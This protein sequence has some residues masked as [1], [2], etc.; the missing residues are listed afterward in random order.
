M[1]ESLIA[2]RDQTLTSEDFTGRKADKFVAV[3]CTF[4]RCDFSGVAV[5]EFVFG[6]GNELS[7]YIECTFDG[8]MMKATGADY[9]VIQSCSFRQVRIENWECHSVDMIDSTFSGMLRRCIFDGI[10]P[11]DFQAYLGRVNTRFAGND[12][13]GC[14][15][16]DVMFNAGIDL[17]QQALP[18]GTEYFWLADLPAAVAVLTAEIEVW[19]QRDLKAAQSLVFIFK[20]GVSRGRTALFG[21][22]ADYRKIYGEVATDAVA[23]LRKGGLEI[24]PPSV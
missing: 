6:G 5:K 10:L 3:N 23:F 15:L 16:I 20:R 24:N 2:F 18:K 13:S 4:V 9:A 1:H 19:G 21:R 17:V 8:A 12:F 14:K 11:K 22:V 7:T